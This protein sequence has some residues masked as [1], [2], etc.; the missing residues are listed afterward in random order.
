M[1]KQI[2]KYS[3]LVIALC[4]SLFSCTKE[5]DFEQ[6]DDLEIS[7]VIET[8]LIF[9]DE[10]ASSFWVNN[11][12]VISIKDSIKIGFFSNKFIVDNL[13]KADFVFEATNSINKGFQVSVDLLN[14]SEQLLHTF[15]LLAS[16][17]TD[18]S[19]VISNHV[20]EFEG[21]TLIALTN[22]SKIVFT[23]SLIPGET[24]NETSL[25]R[26]KLKSKAV[27]YLNIDDDSI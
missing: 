12:E 9:F 25:G 15:T 8:S 26:I 7:P 14:D 16:L 3:F 19:D 23:L 1:Q 13:I 17:S 2:I 11:T 21:D 20:E 6:A 10:P 27:F 18:G 5:I 4:L 24:I 22:T